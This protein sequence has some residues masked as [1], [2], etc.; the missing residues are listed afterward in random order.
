MMKRKSHSRYYDL[1]LDEENK[2][3]W[4]LLCEGC[5]ESKDIDEEDENYAQHLVEEAQFREDVK[6]EEL[7]LEKSRNSSVWS[8]EGCA[9]CSEE[10]VNENP[11]SH[12]NRDFCQDCAWEDD[13]SFCKE[14]MW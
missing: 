9:I 13:K 3:G 10:V 5:R 7:R 2:P 4:G 12:C 8:E 6:A 1:R 11:C 14:C